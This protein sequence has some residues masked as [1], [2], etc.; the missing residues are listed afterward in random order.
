MGRIRIKKYK[1][2]LA[3]KVQNWD[4]H[5]STFLKQIPFG[6]PLE[7][8]FNH[9]FLRGSWHMC[10]SFL[11]LVDKCKVKSLSP[12]YTLTQQS[13]KKLKGF[14]TTDGAVTAFESEC[15]FNLMYCV[16]SFKFGYVFLQRQKIGRRKF[17]FKV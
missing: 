3:Q 6:Q 4:L 13:N 7:M 1:L 9:F 12:V 5:Q 14:Q 10:L 15:P 11:S 17:G 2:F 16:S 8:S